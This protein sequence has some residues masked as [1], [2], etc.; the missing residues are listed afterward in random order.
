MPARSRGQ[1]CRLGSDGFEVLDRAAKGREVRRLTAEGRDGGVDWLDEDAVT[2]NLKKES[3]VSGT[4]GLTRDAKRG[5]RGG[6]YP[7]TY[8][9]KRLRVKENPSKLNHLG[10]VLRHVNAM[11]VARGSYVDDDVTID[12]ELGGLLGRHFAV[13]APCGLQSASR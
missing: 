3:D 12:V 11:L 7:L 8:L 10:R 2:S 4:L 1:A 9:L 5:E 13:R 6:V